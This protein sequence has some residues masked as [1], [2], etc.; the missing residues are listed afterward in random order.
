M[1]PTKPP[2]GDPK[3]PPLASV[4]RP[5]ALSEVIGQ[6]HL[7]GEGAPLRKMVENNK[8]M[9]TIL[10]GLPGTGKTSL[11]SALAKEID[12]DF[13]QLNAT[14]A[15]VKDI[16]AIIE[17]A[18]QSEKRTIVFV[19]EAHRHSKSQQ[20]ILLPVIEDGTITFFGATTE[21]PKFSI[22]STIQS[23]CLI[24]ETSPLSNEDLVELLVRVRRH[25]KDKG[26][27]VKI[28]MDAAKILIKRCS[29][30]ARK[31]ITAIEAAIEIF[32][33]N[34]EVGPEE[35]SKAI[36]NKHVVFD[37]RG[38][39][40]F[41]YAHCYQDAIQDSD[42]NGAMYWLAKWLNSGED[43]AY[44]C[45]RMLITAFEDCAG[46]PHAA[47]TA[48]AACYTTERTG[49]P[50]CMIAMATATVEMALSKRNKIPFYAIH[51][52]MSD[53]QNGGDI[54]V[55]PHM[56]AGGTNYER[57]IKKEYVTGFQHD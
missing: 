24:Y 3:Y 17:T 4:L 22:N 7:V 27:C 50:E 6:K 46:N 31:F 18:Q 41:D 56:R 49:M 54:F 20:D 28:D 19:D 8:P 43:P 40:H 33:K 37:S 30:D 2:Q 42:V 9:S 51:A 14:S 32:A 13:V 1:R 38:Q 12:A 29:G 34:G 35:M 57:I 21:N 52:A 11:V 39:E 47:S 36:P 15:T 53:V 55:P 5:K 23:R 16:R 10:W 44:I 45:R 48:M 25:Y 26:K